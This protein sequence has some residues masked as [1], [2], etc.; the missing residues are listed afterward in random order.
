MGRPRKR[1]GNNQTKPQGN[2][3][4][5]DAGPPNLDPLPYIDGNSLIDPYIGGVGSIFEIGPSAAMPNYG[6][7]GKVD[8]TVM[9][10]RA[11]WHDNGLGDLNVPMDFGT[12]CFSFS[13]PCVPEEPAVPFDIV[14][15]DQTKLH[16]TPPPCSC[17][18]TMYLALS[19]LQEFPSEVSI[20]LRAVQAA[21]NTAQAALRCAQC[22]RC[23][24]APGKSFIEAFQNTMLLGTLLPIIVNCYQR[25]LEMI[26]YE[27][28]L[29]KAAGCQMLFNVS[30]DNDLCG[31]SVCVLTLKALRM[32]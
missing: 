11:P 17:L 22:G 13:Q 8:A 20:A 25:L 29:A 32:L 30:H 21:A 9:N 19:S 28:N 26:D 4:R 24:A 18:A 3:V 10:D 1:R 23:E 27:A 15:E 7:H 2:A 6:S 5:H 31:R 16:A 14:Q 12:G